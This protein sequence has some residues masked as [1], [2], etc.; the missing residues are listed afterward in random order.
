MTTYNVTATATTASTNIITVD[1]VINM[2]SGMPIVFTGTAFGGIVA[3]STYYIKSIVQGFPGYITVS[4]YPNGATFTLTSATGS[5]VGTFNSAGQ[6]VIN[7]GAMPNDGTGDPLRTA[8]NDTNLN[9]DQIFAAGPVLS[10]IQIANNSISTLNTNGNLVLNPNGTG[11]V[12]TNAHIVP[13]NTRIRNLGS[14]SKLWNYLYAQNI[15]VAGIATIANVSI[16]GGNITIPVADLHISGGTNGYVLQTDGTGNLTW[17]EQSGGGG[18]NGTPG[19]ANTQVQF[20][21]AGNFGGQPGFT[22]DNTSNTLSAVKINTTDV[23]NSNG[24]VLENSDLTQGAT[25]AVVIPTNGDANA[26]QVNNTYGNIALQTGAGSGITASW[27]FDNTGN[28]TFPDNSGDGWPV[29]VQRFGMGNIGAWLDG[30]WTIGEFSGNT[31]SGEF[32]I[33]IDPSIEGPVGMTFP[34]SASSNTQ[35]VQIYSTNGSG[36]S[37]YTGPSSWEFNGNGNLTLPDVA[38]VS[39]NY[40]NGQ[41]YGSSANTGNVTFDNNTVIGTGDSFGGGGLNLAIGPD[42]IA[43]GNVQYLQVRGG[44]Q[45]THIHLDT[46]DNTYYDQYFGDDGKFVRLD[47]GSFGNVTVGTYNPGENYRWTFGNDGNTTVP[48]DIQ[49]ITTGFVFTSDISGI[50]TG[51]TTVIVTLTDNTFGGPYTGQVTI[52]GVVGTTEANGTWYFEATE[53]NTFQLYYDA[54]LANPVDGTGWTAYI[55]GG[56]AVAPG[57]SNLSITGGNVSI[58]TNTGNTWTFNDLGGTIFPTLNVQ[59]GDNPSGTIQGQTLLF[60]DINQEAIIST[61]DGI[62]GNEYSQRLVINPGAG[63]NYGE[64]GDIYLWAGRGG[65][66]SGSGGDIKIRGGQGGANTQGGNGGDGGYIR[67]EAGDAA[68]TGGY[69][70]YIEITGGVA[71]YGTPGLPGGQVTITGG[72]GQNGAGGNAN[73]SGGYG[74]TGYN[75]GDINIAGGASNDGPGSAGNINITSSAGTWRFDNT[76]TLTLPDG[77]YLAEGGFNAGSPSATVS[78]NAYSPDGNTVSIQAQGNTSS[79]VL[80]TVD[81]ANATINNWTFDSN[82]NLNLPQGGYIGAAG[83]KGEGTMLTGGKG[84]IASLTSFY[85]NVDALN[86]SSCVTANPDGTLNITTYGDGTGQLGQWVFNDINLNV[87]GNTIIGTPI[88]TGGAGGNSITIQAGSS[89]SFASAPG[90]NLNLVGG[91]GSFGDG[92]GPA[93][94]NVNIASGGS[95]DSHPGNVNI[96]T[97]NNTWAFD[98]TGKLTLP[99]QNVS[100]PAGESQILTGSRRIINGVYTG[101]T[102][103]YAV[104]L[105]GDGSATVVYSTE[106][107]VYINSAKVTFAVQG[108]GVGANWEQFDVVFTPDYVNAGEILWTVSNRIKANSNVEDTIVTVA[109]G[110]S[111]QIQIS[112]QL[113]VGQNGWA[114]FDAVEFGLMVD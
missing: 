13:D 96:S 23:F 26:I 46:G 105:P 40:A 67:M 16:S 14:S 106:A 37:L 53:S 29:N 34:S 45:P 77:T 104:E 11:A 65:D 76:G 54:E 87:P 90:G 64:G 94:G 78:M 63:N 1:T 68:A 114:S 109:Y 73:I 80:E 27:S 88:A 102:N 66:G 55:S 93:G 38:N 33:R 25:A 89:D 19:G 36:I 58:V 42:S 86:Y 49:S 100:G 7:T 107:D 69:A 110:S 103:P 8:F 111:S 12:Q 108:T 24:I 4:G 60:G 82:G 72:V 83:I 98:Y 70:G 97:G 95:Y 101:A 75:G 15:N 51:D 92:Y 62:P 5:M 22:F 57:Y 48:R 28:L 56:L 59:R 18:G 71:G 44:D 41:P 112:L 31:V 2:V 50:T 35:P 43:N 21:N 3:G 39:I 91:Y 79:I 81:N 32:G 6:Q 84:N 99:P 52:S 20:N 17:T 85:A 74:G 47:A 9:F 10:N 61:P 113:P 30:Q